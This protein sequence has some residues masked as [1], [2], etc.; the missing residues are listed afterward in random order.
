MAPTQPT[1]A[2]ERQTLL[3][4]VIHDVKK[5]IE[6]LEKA[7]PQAPAEP[8]GDSRAPPQSPADSDVSVF[9]QTAEVAARIVPMAKRMMEHSGRLDETVNPRLLCILTKLSTGLHVAGIGLDPD[10]RMELY[11]RAVDDLMAVSPEMWA[12]AGVEFR[13][14][15]NSTEEWSVPTESGSTRVIPLRTEDNLKNKTV[16][17]LVA[18][19]TSGAYM[20]FERMDWRSQDASLD[21]YC[22]SIGKYY[23]NGTEVDVTGIGNIVGCELTGNR[24]EIMVF[25]GHY[26][27]VREV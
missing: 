25:G 4:K 11:S 19:I 6:E 8:Q 22:S 15:P 23:N 5:R 2:E 27:I 14:N 17:G 13:F 3:T 9:F 18:P 1:P 16:E 24:A 10:A 21:G 7:D 20:T 26:Q 12:E